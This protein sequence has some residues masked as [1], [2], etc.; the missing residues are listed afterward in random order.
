MMG[1]YLLL[2]VM[3]FKMAGT[4]IK[5]IVDKSFITRKL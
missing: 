4:C 1:H 3:V 5:R 2:K